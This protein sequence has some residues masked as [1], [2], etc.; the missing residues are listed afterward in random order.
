[1]KSLFT[2]VLSALMASTLALVLGHAQ[3]PLASGPTFEVASVKANKSSGGRRGLGMQPGGRFNAENV[4]V[5]L[6]IQNAYR[7]QPNQLIGGPGWLDS[8]R[9]DIVAKADPA[10]MTPPPGG[11]GSGPSAVDLMVRALLA[12]RFK[13]VVHTET[14]EQDIYALVLARPDGKLGPQ[15]K[16]VSDECAAMIAARRGGPP[17][18]ER[19]APPPPPPPGPPQPGEKV[20]C[21]SMMM[22]PGNLNSGGLGMQQIAQA[23]SQ[24]SG[25]GGPMSAGGR[26]VQDKT[27][28]T[29]MYEFALQWTPDQ[30]PGGRGFDGG[31]PPPGFPGIDPNGP[32]LL[33]AV[34]E[35]LGLKL[36][37]RKAPVDVLVIDRIEHP[38]ED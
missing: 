29:G 7:V 27:G 32:S 22:G 28:L 21:G 3:S 35:Q 8:D 34:Q 23:L 17:R 6:L 1:M 12:D 30:L 19:G 31:G 11:P 5:R 26:M 20:P 2:S 18:G 14:R 10:L 15:L 36:E 33:T 4:P 16:P 9:F 13:L 38:T 25:T 24:A 37:S